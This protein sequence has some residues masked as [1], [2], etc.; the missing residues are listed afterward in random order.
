MTYLKP[1]D[2]TAEERAI[3][4]A[5]AIREFPSFGATHAY[6]QT[7]GAMECVVLARRALFSPAAESARCQ[8]SHE[9]HGDV[10]ECQRESGHSG[11]HEC[12][13]WSELGKKGAEHP[14]PKVECPNCRGQVATQEEHVSSRNRD[15]FTCQPAASG[16][17]PPQDEVKAV[18]H[19]VR[20]CGS[21]EAAALILALS[22][23][24]W[25]SQP[26]PTPP[27][28]MPIDRARQIAAQCWCDPETESIEMDARLAEAFARRLV[29]FRRSQPA[30]AV[31][32][33]EELEHVLASAEYDAGYSDATGHSVAA[34]A[35]R[36]AIAAVRAQA[37]Q[38]QGV[39]MRG[40]IMQ[41]QQCAVV[42]DNRGA[43][44]NAE[45]LR[46]WADAALAELNAAEGR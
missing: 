2:L 25:R 27:S 6:A 9:F 11:S 36:S 16:E 38:P 21:D 29:E 8:H 28:E 15:S 7:K 41:A 19:N 44:T 32:M 24:K 3:W 22:L 35:T 34:K 40:L 17:M 31:A 18:A 45:A 43:P 30:P 1:S 12:K 13:S 20:E 14:E 39:K 26:A 10:W 4:D 37:S 42:L 23:V 5:L 46:L 33:T